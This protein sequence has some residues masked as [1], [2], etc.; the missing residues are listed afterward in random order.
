MQIVQQ[1]SMPLEFVTTVREKFWDFPK[2]QEA[3]QNIV[4]HTYNPSVVADSML[5]FWQFCR[6]GVQIDKE[7]L[8]LQKFIGKLSLGTFAMVGILKFRK[9]DMKIDI[10]KIFMAGL[11]WKF[12]VSQME[13][14]Q[15]AKFSLMELA[16][17]RS[18]LTTGPMVQLSMRAI[19]KLEYIERRSMLFFN[20]RYQFNREFEEE[21]LNKVWNSHESGF[22]KFKGMIV[23]FIVLKVRSGCQVNGDLAW[24][25]KQHINEK[26]RARAC[27]EDPESSHGQF[28]A[29][30]PEKLDELW[31][32]HRQFDDQQIN[33]ILWEC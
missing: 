17:Q 32:E 1:I 33:K 24:E 14:T 11:A 21:I 16:R 28:L 5:Q 25:F 30:L 8:K 31:A 29:K 13:A 15:I 10:L 26:I 6:L 9:I 3:I 23:Q 4:E 19:A 2:V 7:F 20:F 27:F 22:E 18:S 12:T